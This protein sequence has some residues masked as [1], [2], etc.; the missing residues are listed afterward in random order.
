MEEN[1]PHFTRA[2]L[3]LLEILAKSSNIIQE[4]SKMA[5]DF[6]MSSVWDLCDFEDLVLIFVFIVRNDI[7]QMSMIIRG[8]YLNKQA[9]DVRIERRVVSRCKT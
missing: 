5:S 9:T 3:V 1:E 4:R 6:L 7:I 8:R 2:F